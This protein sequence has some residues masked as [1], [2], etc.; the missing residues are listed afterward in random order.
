MVKKTLAFTVFLDLHCFKQ[1]CLTCPPQA[2]HKATLSVTEVGTEAAAATIIEG[3]TSALTP[4]IK[5]NRPFLDFILENS[6]RGILFMGKINNRT[7]I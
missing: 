1:D 4:S 7:A 6:T 2:S 5:I 3:L